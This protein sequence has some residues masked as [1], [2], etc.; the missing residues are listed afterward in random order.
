MSR[1]ATLQRLGSCAD[2]GLSVSSHRVANRDVGCLGAL[3]N[4]VLTL[5]DRLDAALRQRRTRTDS[6]KRES[7]GES[8]RERSAAR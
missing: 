7:A 5:H 2:C 8:T 4:Q 3:G 6:V 1:Q